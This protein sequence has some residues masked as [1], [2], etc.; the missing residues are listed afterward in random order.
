[1]INMHNKN[2]R[3][4]IRLN[5]SFDKIQMIR[6]VG[7]L[8][9]ADF[10]FDFPSESKVIL[11]HLSH[12]FNIKYS[13]NTDDL[14]VIE[15]I[16]ITHEEQPMCKIGSLSKPLVYPK[17]MLDKCKAKWNGQRSIKFSFTG[18]MTP[19]RKRCLDEWVSLHF[20]QQNIDKNKIKV[21]KNS[22]K[23]KLLNMLHFFDNRANGKVVFKNIGLQI[24]TSSQGRQ[25]PIKVWDEEY[26]DTLAKT[27]FVL[28][29]DGDFTWTY[30]FF[31]AIICGAIPVVENPCSLYGGFEYFS[32]KDPIEKLFYSQE[33]AER[34]FHRV[35][36]KFA[37]K[38]VDLNNQISSL[39]NS[40]TQDFRH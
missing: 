13:I 6:F 17:E 11:D 8:L 20:Y 37:F 40:S 15:D 9:E 7:A 33:I 23:D 10:D 21:S 36:S 35:E 25:F 29:P 28:C 30:R 27:Q 5:V 4:R 32:M 22:R 1:M 34:N 16:S 19:N 18:L 39:I 2:L 31:E 38:K 3:K 24:F 14:P 12:H 26:Y